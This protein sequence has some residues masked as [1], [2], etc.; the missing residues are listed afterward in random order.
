MLPPGYRT[1][2]EIAL[3]GLIPEPHS[4]DAKPASDNDR[5]EVA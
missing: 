2:R 3:A 5:L 4:T 1:M